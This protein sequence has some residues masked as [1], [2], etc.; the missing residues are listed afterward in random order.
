MDRQQ[1][2]VPRFGIVADDLTGALDTGL[3]FARTG[4]ETMVH[5]SPSSDDTD[6]LVLDSESRNL[7]GTIAYDRVREAAAFLGGRVVYKKIDSTLRGNI[8]FELDAVMDELS[9]RR[10]LVTPALPAYGRTLTDGRL[11]V[12]GTPLRETDFTDDP[13]CPSTDHLPT[14]LARQSRRRVG[15]IRREVV[16]QG[17]ETLARTIEQRAEGI[18]VIDAS[19]QGHLRTIADAAAALAGHSVSCGSAGLACALPLGFGID[20]D[21]PRLRQMPAKGGP[22]L[23]I[24]GSRRDVTLRQIE[25]AISARGAALVEMD[26]LQ[27]ESTVGIVARE[28][29]NLLSESKTVIVTTAF[30]P[31][32]AEKAQAIAQSL[33]DVVAR[34]VETRPLS[35]L[36]LTGGDVAVA[37]CR[38]LDVSSIRIEGETAPGVPIG[39]IIGRRHGD[40]RLITKAG[41]FGDEDVLIRAIDYLRGADD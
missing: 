29:R 31:F 37:V 19:T 30:K 40:L 39:T 3:Q 18:L 21:E 5:L 41:G 34:V 16:A 2:N 25:R 6:V 26:P 28:T 7:S 33:G 12:N 11:H 23:I 13:L 4:L 27:I 35:G 1:S 8:G 36:V 22:V 14:L 9:L 38:E 32:V 24:A 20:A 17:G 10:A 15:H